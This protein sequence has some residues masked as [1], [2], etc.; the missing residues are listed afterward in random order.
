MVNITS[1]CYWNQIRYNHS[2]LHQSEQ[3]TVQN[4]QYQHK[5]QQ[6]WPYQQINSIWVTNVD[7][8]FCDSIRW[9][10]RSLKLKFIWLYNEWQLRNV[11]QF[12]PNCWYCGNVWFIECIFPCDITC[13]CQFIILVWI[14][15]ITIVYINILLRTGWY[16]FVSL[17]MIGKICDKTISTWTIIAFCW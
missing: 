4:S 5:H 17:W 3:T 13:K 15:R 6:F 7:W 11:T 9:T 2:I 1:N 10:N 8:K 12:V 16:C 14:T